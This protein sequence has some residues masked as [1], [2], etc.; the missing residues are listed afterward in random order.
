MNGSRFYT[1]HLNGIH[2]LN[3]F[4]YIGSIWSIIHLTKIIYQPYIHFATSS[5]HQLEGFTMS[6]IWPSHQLTRTV[7]QKCMNSSLKSHTTHHVVIYFVT[8]SYG[9]Q[10][11]KPGTNWL[12]LHLRRPQ[13]TLPNLSLSLSL[14][15][16]NFRQKCRTHN[17]KIRS[18]QSCY[19]DLLLYI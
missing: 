1:I 18:R 19:Y 13:G 10:E 3:D 14:S 7:D 15:L 4:N 17:Y 11:C 5:C 16:P 2:L 9:H 8:S 6:T 12:L